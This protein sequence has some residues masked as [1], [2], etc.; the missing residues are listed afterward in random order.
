M[1][2]ADIRDRVNDVPLSC[3]TS[4]K[5]VPWISAAMPTSERRS[6]SLEDANNIF[7]FTFESSGDLINAIAC[8]QTHARRVDKTGSRQRSPCSVF[9]RG[10]RTRRAFAKMGV[11]FA[12]VQGRNEGECG[13]GDRKIDERALTTRRT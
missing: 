9:R 11:T 10:R 8:A 7:C 13:A 3:A 2:N 6:A 1:S 4:L 12:G 5:S